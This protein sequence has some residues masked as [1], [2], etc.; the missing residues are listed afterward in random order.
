MTIYVEALLALSI[1]R[2]EHS[3]VRAVDSVLNLLQ[4]QGR[5]RRIAIKNEKELLI[6]LERYQNIAYDAH[7]EGYKNVEDSE[8]YMCIDEVQPYVVC[9]SLNNDKSITLHFIFCCGSHGESLKLDPIDGILNKRVVL[10]KM[11][12]LHKLGI[13]NEALMKMI[14]LTIQGRNETAA[15][16]YENY[17]IPV[18]VEKAKDFYQ[19]G[20]YIF[21][22]NA[23]LYADL[24]PANKEE[25]SNL[26]RTNTFFFREQASTIPSKYLCAVTDKIMENPMYFDPKIDQEESLKYMRFDKSS[27]SRCVLNGVTPANFFP[28]Y[29]LQEEIKIFKKRNPQLFPAVKSRLLL[30]NEVGH[31]DRYPSSIKT[32]PNIQNHISH[33]DRY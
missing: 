26:L 13:K 11:A 9:Y 19:E 29:P 31:F 18:A 15:M 4:S 1:R 30:R 28:D 25:K 20:F 16:K 27:L 33:R 14:L 23:I 6:A 21:E 8:E 17:H 32:D 3:I 10:L 24:I 12:A 22:K 2:P 7:L 5:P